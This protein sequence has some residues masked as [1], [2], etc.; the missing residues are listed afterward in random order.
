MGG[1]EWGCGD[2]GC[3]SGWR[4]SA[5]FLCYGALGAA[6]GGGTGGEG[7]RKIEGGD[8]IGGV[9]WRS[10]W[11]D[12]AG[13]QAGRK[14]DGLEGCLWLWSGV[15]ARWQ[16]GD[17]LYCVKGLGRRSGSRLKI[18]CQIVKIS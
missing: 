17:T 10:G 5:G 2:A 1:L 12:R 7:G 13:V 9:K 3:G 8:G 11:I 15:A 4:G 14:G 16:G 18:C 6:E